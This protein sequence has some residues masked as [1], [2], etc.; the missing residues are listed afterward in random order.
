[1]EQVGHYAIHDFNLANTAATIGNALSYI[2]LRVLAILA[3]LVFTYG[4]L[5]AEV[6]LAKIEHVTEPVVFRW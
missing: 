2:A 4:L 1:M 3:L 5:A 6:E